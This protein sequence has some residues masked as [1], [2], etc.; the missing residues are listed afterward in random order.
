[1]NLMIEETGD[2][3]LP[4]AVFL[5]YCFSLRTLSSRG[6]IG[7]QNNTELRLQEKKIKSNIFYKAV[8]EDSSSVKGLNKKLKE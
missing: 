6:I 5:N 1:M 8:A 2:E 4:G 3:K 7:V